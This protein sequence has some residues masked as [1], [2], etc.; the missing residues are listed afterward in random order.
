MTY[1]AL[2]GICLSMEKPLLLLTL[3]L[4]ALLAGWD[5]FADLQSSGWG[6]HVALEALLL[7]ATSLGFFLILRQ[8]LRVRLEAQ[9]LRQDIKRISG[10]NEEYRKE[11]QQFAQGLQCSID[12]QMDRWRLT[13]AE[14]EVAYLL[15]KG[16]SSKEMAQIRNTSEKTVRQQSS[17]V[18]RKSQLGG[19]ADLAAFFLEDLLSPSSQSG[20]IEYDQYQDGDR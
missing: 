2:S 15:L 11:V 19:R 10:Q 12:R 5:I 7:A 20:E 6:L 1:I 16:F 4:V 17:Q 14:K 3:G 18:Y 8:W 9:Q 13:E